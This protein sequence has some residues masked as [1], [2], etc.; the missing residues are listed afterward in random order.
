MGN[1]P[2][3]ALVSAATRTCLVL[4]C[5]T[6]VSLWGC[7]REEEMTLDEIARIVSAGKEEILGKTVSKP[8]R[9]EEFVPGVRGGSWYAS[10]TEDPKSFNLQVAERDA[11]TMGIVSRLVDS[12]VEYDYVKRAFKPGCA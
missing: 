7:A 3:R 10:M 1:S 11:T 2:Y 9:G 4:A 12:L 5:V 6:S 8:W